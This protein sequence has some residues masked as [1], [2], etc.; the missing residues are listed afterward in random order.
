MS[1]EWEQA[2]CKQAAAMAENDS[3]GGPQW[4]VDSASFATASR[5]KLL[6]INELESSSGNHWDIQ[7]R[8]PIGPARSGRAARSCVTLG[9]YLE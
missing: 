8:Q 5:A 6:T 9:P 4:V 2:G 7:F 3:R 1:G